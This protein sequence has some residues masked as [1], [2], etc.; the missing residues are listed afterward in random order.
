MYFPCKEYF[1]FIINTNVNILRATSHE[2][3]C[4]RFSL[5]NETKVNRIN[6]MPILYFS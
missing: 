4:M 2:M 1:L 6:K 3:I 5:R